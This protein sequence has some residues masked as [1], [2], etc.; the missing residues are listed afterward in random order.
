[1]RKPTS[2][3][4]RTFIGGG[5]WA[6]LSFGRGIRASQASGNDTLLSL[7]GTIVPDSDSEVWRSGPVASSFLARLNAVAPAAKAQ[8]KKLTAE[9][10]T[11]AHRHKDM[12]F[13]DLALG[14]RTKLVK[15]HL[16]PQSEF[17]APLYTVRS[18]AVSAFYS[19][20]IGYLRT[21][22]RETTQFVGYPEYVRSA[23]TWE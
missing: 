4:R 12:P 21:G 13:A 9:L 10:D 22:Y 8:V 15:E 20:E 23:E 17:G 7:A 19:S 6:A 5:F 16:S 11:L 18:A 14:E 2:L 1:M 3:L